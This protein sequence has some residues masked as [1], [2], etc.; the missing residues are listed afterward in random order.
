[1]PYMPNPQ[2]KTLWSQ[3]K[4]TLWILKS[5]G[6][7]KRIINRCQSFFWLKYYTQW[8]DWWGPLNHG[9]R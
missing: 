2:Q 7:E 3:I 9:Q 5:F 4:E 8:R 6:K 1:M